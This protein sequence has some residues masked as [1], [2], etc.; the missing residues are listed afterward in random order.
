MVRFR[1]ETMPSVT[2]PARPSGAPMASTE[3][4]TFRLSESPSVAGVRLFASTLITARS[5]SGSV[6]TTV[7]ESTLPSS[8]WTSML[9]S[10][11]VPPRVTTCVLVRMCPSSSRMIPDPLPEEPEPGNFDGHDAGRCLHSGSGDRVDVVLVV[12]HHSVG[13]T[14]GSGRGRAVIQ[15]G[16]CR[17]RHASAEES[18]NEHGSDDGAGAVSAPPRCRP[19]A[20]DPGCRN[21]RRSRP[22]SGPAFPDW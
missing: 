19:A 5:E 16:V 3:S 13:L 6:P 21:G 10:A 15:D 14:G 17:D 1:V 12:D 4:P 2:V 18:G 20:G 22:R 7:A 9:G 8:V 11:T